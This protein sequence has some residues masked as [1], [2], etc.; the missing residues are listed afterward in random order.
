M[1]NRLTGHWLIE[2]I[3]DPIMTVA[4]FNRLTG[5]CFIIMLEWKT[6]GTS[7]FYVL[8]L[9]V[10]RWKAVG[11][12]NEELVLF[13]VHFLFGPRWKTART[14]KYNDLLVVFLR[15]RIQFSL[16]GCLFA[17]VRH[18]ELISLRLRHFNCA[19][20]NCFV[21]LL[22]PGKHFL[23]HFAQGGQPFT[24]VSLGSANERSGH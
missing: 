2:L 3:A 7:N 14:T 18:L 13:Y 15:R 9:F 23:V 1:F 5:I 11:T 20:G 21:L 19:D 24:V 4:N 6:I 10:L 22:M 17:D 8:L 12:S 16:L